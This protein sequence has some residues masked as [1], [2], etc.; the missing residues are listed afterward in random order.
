MLPGKPRYETRALSGDAAA[1][2]H[3]WS[4]Q[5]RMSVLGVG[6]ADYPAGNEGILDSTQSALVANIHGNLIEES[7]IFRDGLAGRAVVA[8]GA[9]TVLRARL[10]VS[11]R[12]LYQL[13]VLGPGNDLSAADVELFFSSFSPRNAGPGN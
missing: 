1:T 13:A 5:V 3:L 4:T 10:W 6:Y 11:G 12:R 7:R 8:E 2:M 9:D